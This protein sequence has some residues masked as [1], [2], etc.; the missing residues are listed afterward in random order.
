MNDV[1]SAPSGAKTSPDSPT[2]QLVLRLWRNRLAVMGFALLFVVLFGAVFAGVLTPYDPLAMTVTDRVRPPS[3]AHLMGTDNFG[4]DIFA[5]VLYG[6]RL[7]LEVG[8]AVMLLT[9]V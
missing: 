3:A 7:S 1:A 6:A 2:R 8:L 4:R 5:R 9:V